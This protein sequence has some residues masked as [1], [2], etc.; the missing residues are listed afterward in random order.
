MKC[1]QHTHAYTPLVLALTAIGQELE[2]PF[3]CCIEG[4]MIIDSRF[5]FLPDDECRR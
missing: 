4:R 5:P 1:L 3:F 2:M